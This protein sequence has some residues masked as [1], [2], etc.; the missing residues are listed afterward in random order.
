MDKKSSINVSG[1]YYSPLDE[2][3]AGVTTGTPKRVEFLQEITVEPTQEITK[4]YG[5]GKI[6]EMAVSNGPVNVSSQFHRVPIE[7]KKVLFGLGDLNGLVTYGPNTT[8]PYVAIAFYREFSDGSKEWMGLPKGM[9]T[10]PSTTGSSKGE[11]VEFSSEEVT[12]EFMS[13]EVEGAPEELSYLL[14]KDDKATTTQ[15]DA[16][17]QAVFGQN[18][19]DYVAPTGV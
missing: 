4:A 5:D 2:T 12:A 18:H 1:F 7:D 15:R 6:A 19:P 16:L 9:F 14:G 11:S 13:R 8:P 17:F 3:G 10:I